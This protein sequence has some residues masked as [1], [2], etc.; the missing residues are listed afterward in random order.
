[1]K[2][3][4]SRKGMTLVELVVTIC[5][6]SI[7]SGMGVGIFA[8]TMQRYLTASLTSDQ[9]HKASL[10]EE[11]LVTAAKTAKSVDF[12][13][14]PSSPAS[15][16]TLPSSTLSGIYFAHTT[17]QQDFDMYEYDSVTNTK[18][19]SIKLEGIKTITITLKRHQSLA[20]PNDDDFVYMDYKIVTTDDYTL[21]GSTIM[22]NFPVS[23]FTESGSGHTVSTVPFVV[24]DK[25]T[26]SA[27]VFGS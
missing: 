15:P 10:C 13:P 24:G 18:S 11:Y 16:D 17:G 20:A 4:R 26:N 25:V 14:D 2:K 6:L 1:M 22:N 9:Q 21:Q 7:V 5:V 8:S 23:S 27:V 12:I 19:S 3:L